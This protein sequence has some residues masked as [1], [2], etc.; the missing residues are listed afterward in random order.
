M[1]NAYRLQMALAGRFLPDIAPLG[2]A[3]TFKMR[4]CSSV[5]TTKHVCSTGFEL[6]EEFF[7]RL[8]QLRRCGKDQLHE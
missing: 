4:N 3:S 1:P 5:C 6:N 7:V 8:V 2:N